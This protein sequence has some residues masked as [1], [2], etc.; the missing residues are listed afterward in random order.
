MF[1]ETSICPACRGSYNRWWRYDSRCEAT[2]ATT[3]TEYN[4]IA[5]GCVDHW[6]PAS[7]LPRQHAKHAAADG[8]APTTGEVS[9]LSVTFRACSQNTKYA[10]YKPLARWQADHRSC[11]EQTQGEGIAYWAG[12]YTVRHIRLSE[13]AIHS[14]A[15]F[16]EAHI[17]WLMSHWEVMQ[18][19][20]SKYITADTCGPAVD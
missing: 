1:I 17:G 3:S 16:L 6:R 2:I 14:N 8:R 10:H 19:I 13:V 11:N 5:C 12:A 18:C 15:R 7:P 20:T 9:G 4:L